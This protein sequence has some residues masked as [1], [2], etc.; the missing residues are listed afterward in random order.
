M[1]MTMM[2]RMCGSAP[3]S[4]PASGRVIRLPPSRGKAKGRNRNY[5]DD[6]DDRDDCDD[7]EDQDDHEDHDQHDDCD[8]ADHNDHEDHVDDADHNGDS[9]FD[10]SEVILGTFSQAR[11]PRNHKRKVLTLSRR[12]FVFFTLLPGSAPLCERRM[13]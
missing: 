10:K 2:M 11:A 7:R 12:R 9:D 13:M 5:H 6:R 3:V 8:D 4:P 1:T